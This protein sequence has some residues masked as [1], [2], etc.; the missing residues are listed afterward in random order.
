[1]KF[2]IVANAERKKF[3]TNSSLVFFTLKKEEPSR[4]FAKQREIENERR[5]KESDSDES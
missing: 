1:M 5:K 4:V 2:P 3:C